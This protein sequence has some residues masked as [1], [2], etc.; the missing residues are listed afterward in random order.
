MN[1]MEGLIEKM[2]L[3]LGSNAPAT[4]EERIDQI[5]ERLRLELKLLRS[6]KS[7][8]LDRPVWWLA[9]DAFEHL[10][11]LLRHGEAD[12]DQQRMVAEF[13]RR[14]VGEGSEKI[15]YGVLGL[16]AQN[17]RPDESLNRSRA[18]RALKAS[19]ATAYDLP[20]GEE[21]VGLGGGEAVPVVDQR[22]PDFNIWI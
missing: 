6:G 4:Q 15:M 22:G 10:T 3:E 21:E 19:M 17:H 16:P 12:L 2:D 13:L 20:V 9:L 18:V 11:F 8:L 7:D 14:S 1:D 5:R